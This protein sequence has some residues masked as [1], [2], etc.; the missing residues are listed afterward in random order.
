MVDIE[1]SDH[2]DQSRLDFDQKIA[3]HTLTGELLH[4][5]AKRLNLTVSEENTRCT[6]HLEVTWSVYQQLLVGEWMGLFANARTSETQMDFEQDQVIELR[7]M[8]RQSLIPTA[9]HN[10]TEVELVLQ[11]LLG[12]STEA[13]KLRNS[14]SWLVIEVKQQLQLSAELDGSGTLKRGYR[15]LWAGPAVVGASYIAARVD[16]TLK[17][18][19]EGYLNRREI[20]YEW[21]TE[22]IIRLTYEGENGTWI[23]LVR[24]DEEKQVCL[25]YSIFPEFVPEEHRGEM[26]VYLIE[27]NYDLVVGNFELD[28]TDGELRYR[29][30]IDAENAHLTM[31]L[32]GQLFK[33]NVVNM[34]HYFYVIQEGIQEGFL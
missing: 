10:G 3:F 22:S 20:P 31:E 25:V 16:Y 4:T 12:D 34:D 28:T 2:A 9:C 21:I 6:L 24:T 32:F 27:E 18:I 5:T 30:S 13:H 1:T 7:V 14:E 17:E 33:T 26:A 23:V 19:V 11:T 15:T 8:L 29:T